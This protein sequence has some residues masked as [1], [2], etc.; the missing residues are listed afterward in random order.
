MFD[1]LRFYHFDH[2]VR[3][4]EL[5]CGTGVYTRKLAKKFPGLGITAIDIS[6][7]II[8]IA[9]EKLK[10]YKNVK[11]KVAS[12]YNTGLRAS[13]VDVVFGFYVLHHLDLEKVVSEISRVL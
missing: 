1:V 9:K 6:E 4:L 8:S 7:K 11:F 3:V 5:G 2:G 10:K 13:S 12:A